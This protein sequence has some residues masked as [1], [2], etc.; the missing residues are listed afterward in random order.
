MGVG[1]E[2]D[3]LVSVYTMF[4]TLLPQADANRHTSS[5]LSALTG[6]DGIIGGMVEESGE[7]GKHRSSPHVCKNC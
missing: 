7:Q 2:V 6:I 4:T 3:V 1:G 5:G